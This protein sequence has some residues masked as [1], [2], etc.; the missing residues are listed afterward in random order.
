ME[1]EPNLRQVGAA[2]RQDAPPAKPPS[3][4]LVDGKGEAVRFL[5]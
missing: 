3:D 4:F 2:H 5:L 1:I